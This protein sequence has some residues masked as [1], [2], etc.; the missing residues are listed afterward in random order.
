[1]H[2]LILPYF[3]FVLITDPVIHHKSDL[4]EVSFVYMFLFTCF[5]CHLH[6]L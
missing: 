1:M 3:F 4:S 5:P 2:L 6:Y